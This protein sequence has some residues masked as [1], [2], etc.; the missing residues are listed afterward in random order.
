MTND[1]GFELHPGAAQDVTEIWEFIA[2]DNPLAARRIREDLLNAIR[3]LVPFP[4]QGHQRPD[5]TSRPLRFQ[6]IRDYLI[7]YA[8]DQKPLVV[9]AVLHGR[10][11][12][13]IIAAILRGRE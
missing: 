2:E 7:A 11:N 9:I 10:C 4:H 1:Q 5:L 8:P 6:T 13:R 3:K 12:P